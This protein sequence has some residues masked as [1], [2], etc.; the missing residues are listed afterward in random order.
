MGSWIYESELRNA[1]GLERIDLG[2]TSMW[3]LIKAKRVYKIAMGQ[4][5][6]LY[7]DI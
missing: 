7:N 5:A 6:W 4:V 3:I 2:V 1:T